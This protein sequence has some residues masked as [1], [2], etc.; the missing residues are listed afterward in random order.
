MNSD[1]TAKILNVPESNVKQKLGST[2]KTKSADSIPQTQLANVKT[3]RKVIWT[4]HC[5]WF[6][7]AYADEF[8]YKACNFLIVERD[9]DWG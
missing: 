3:W 9:G 4:E 2:I 7:Q 8:G 5:C 1:F 6:S